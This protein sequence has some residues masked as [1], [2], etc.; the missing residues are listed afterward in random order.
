MYILYIYLEKDEHSKV[1]SVKTAPD[2]ENMF[3]ITRVHSYKCIAYYNKE[4]D[5]N[6]IK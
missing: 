2:I 1:W 5:W 3:A 4:K 6:V